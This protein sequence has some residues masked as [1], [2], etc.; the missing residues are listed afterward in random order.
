MCA[1]G[2]ASQKHGYGGSILLGGKLLYFFGEWSPELRAAKV[3]IAVLE[4]WVILMITT[5]W[6]HLF[7]GKKIIIRTDSAASCF[8]LNKLWSDSDGMSVICE[9]WEELQH[10]FSFE[11]LVT[12]CA[13]TA[14]RLPDICSRMEEPAIAPAMIEVLRQKGVP[15]TLERVEAKWTAGRV[16]IRVERLLMSV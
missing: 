15:A 2:D 9:L 12:H 13:G 5:T 11:G 6:G 14:N 7:K 1:N 10:T 16:D 8:C 3:N 4:A